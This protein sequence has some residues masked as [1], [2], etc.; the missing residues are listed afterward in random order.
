M[1]T[2]KSAK[3]QFLFEYQKSQSMILQQ[4]F[5]ET[6]TSIENFPLSE[7][8]SAIRDLR[9]RLRDY[10]LTVHT[11]IITEKPINLR[12]KHKSKATVISSP[13]VSRSPGR[14]VGGGLGAGSPLGRKSRSA[15][16]TRHTDSTTA[17]LQDQVCAED[18]PLLELLLQQQ[19]Q[20]Q[21]AMHDHM[22]DNVRL[23]PAVMVEIA[24]TVF[25]DALG[26]SWRQYSPFQSPSTGGLP[27][28][29]VSG[30][31]SSTGTGSS[32]DPTGTTG[33][34]K[35]PSSP[36]PRLPPP[37]VRSFAGILPVSF[38]H[39]PSASQ[40]PTATARSGIDLGLQSI[41][42][43]SQSWLSPPADNITEEGEEDEDQ[44]SPAGFQWHTP[45]EGQPEK[46]PRK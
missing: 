31:K 35:D 8:K 41:S 46:R 12:P 4:K 19:Q 38:T 16:I 42:L 20:Q 1:F 14:A 32:V 40:Q 17:L 9:F 7:A 44:L 24:S 29:A 10:L 27:S 36:S 39:L 26:G 25:G 43:L 18:R 37:P 45:T 6:W 2:Y 22:D 13:A 11:E 30:V 28:A 15:S 5:E 34:V 33:S 3:L 23:T 21:H